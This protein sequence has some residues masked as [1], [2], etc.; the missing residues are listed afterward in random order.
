[1]ED[2][3]RTTETANRLQPLE[4][5]SFKKRKLIQMAHDRNIDIKI[6]PSG[7]KRSKMNQTTIASSLRLLSWTIE[8]VLVEQEKSLI[9][10]KILENLTIQQVL[11]KVGDL[12][13]VRVYLKRG[14][15][16]VISFNFN[17]IG[18]QSHV[19]FSAFGLDSV[20]MFKRNDYL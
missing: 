15:S 7:M 2:V 14:D 8:I 19:L 11:E 3:Q 5:S 1:L 13:N 6:M 16:P 4:K 18:Q 10:N 12:I 20:G 9:L 17:K